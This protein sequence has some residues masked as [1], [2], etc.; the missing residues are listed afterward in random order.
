M[1]KIRNSV[2][3]TNSSSVH[4]MVIVTDDELEKL[5]SEELVFDEEDNVVISKEEAIKSGKP[6][7]T[8]EQWIDNIYNR[9][10]SYDVEEYTCKCGEHINMLI[11][12]GYNG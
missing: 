10:L 6:Y 8:I 7:F 3:E 11:E 5:N 4:N 1:K 9:N 2:F 12:H